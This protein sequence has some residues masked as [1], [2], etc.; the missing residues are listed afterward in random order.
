MEFKY[1]GFKD[2]LPTTGIGVKKPNFIERISDE[3][4]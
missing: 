4:F 1:M 3:E 2:Q